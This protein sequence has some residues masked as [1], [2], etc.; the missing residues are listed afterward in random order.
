MAFVVIFHF[1]MTSLL[2]S[3]TWCLN[4]HR[5]IVTLV[6]VDT[7]EIDDTILAMKI[8][9][10]LAADDFYGTT[11]DTVKIKLRNPIR[12]VQLPLVL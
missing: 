6:K 1:V 4:N 9:V 12:R 7:S 10:C 3:E 8:D 2:M 5:P 11:V